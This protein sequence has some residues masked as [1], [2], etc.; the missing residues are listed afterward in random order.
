MNMDKVKI[1]VPKFE[2]IEKWYHKT[3]KIV[4]WS[5]KKHF[6]DV[7]IQKYPDSC[8]GTGTFQL[9]YALA[10]SYEL[11]TVY[12]LL[13]TAEGYS[14][15]FPCFFQRIA[16]FLF[17]KFSNAET[18]RSRTLFGSMTSSMNPLPAAM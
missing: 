7:I 8:D 5:L 14:G 2:K 11:T 13:S 12:C 1:M 6:C 16:F 17:F 9:L 10:N 15:I 3:P 4:L 18:R